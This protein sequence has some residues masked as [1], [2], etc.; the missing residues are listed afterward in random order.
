MPNFPDFPKIGSKVVFINEG[1]WKGQLERYREIFI[2]FTD[3]LIIEKLDVRD[4]SSYYK[5]EG[6]GGWY[7]TVMFKP[8]NE[9]PSVVQIENSSNGSMKNDG[10]KVTIE[11]ERLVI[12]IGI[13]T[14]GTAI[15]QGPYFDRLWGVGREAYISDEEKFGKSILHALKREVNETGETLVHKMLDAAAEYVFEYG[16][17]GIDI[18]GEIL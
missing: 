18:K 11:D 1:G 5:F 3:Q 8:I 16:E 7:N 10:L 4:W 9:T 17:E 2:P 14:L 15:L 6:I 13:E 12:S